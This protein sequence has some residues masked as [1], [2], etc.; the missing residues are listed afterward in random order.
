MSDSD[1]DDLGFALGGLATGFVLWLLGLVG[2]FFL[3]FG[4]AR[5]GQP[6]PRDRALP[7]FFSVM[8]LGGVGGLLIARR[9]WRRHPWL[10][11]SAAVLVAPWLLLSAFYFL[12]SGLRLLARML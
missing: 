3:F 9:G 10:C 2:V 5:R 4:D 7:F 1:Q 8:A 11:G 12:A 6:D